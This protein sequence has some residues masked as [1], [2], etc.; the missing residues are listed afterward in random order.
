MLVKEQDD[1]GEVQHREPPRM[2]LRYSM[3]AAEAIIPA[4]PMRAAH[5]CPPI[6]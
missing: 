3:S 5:A 4:T 2:A 1:E 6:A